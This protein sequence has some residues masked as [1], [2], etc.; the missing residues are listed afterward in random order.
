MNCKACK[1]MHYHYVTARTFGKDIVRTCRHKQVD[2]LFWG[3]IHAFCTGLDF[4]EDEPKGAL[5]MQTLLECLGKQNQNDLSELN[6]KYQM[7]V[8]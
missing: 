5:D 1:S 2:L 6:R 8:S 3:V 7:G 4:V